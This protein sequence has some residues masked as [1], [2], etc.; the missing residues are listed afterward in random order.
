MRLGNPTPQAVVDAHSILTSGIHGVSS[1]VSGITDS[2]TLQNKIY[3]GD[4]KINNGDLEFG[5][6]CYLGERS[7]VFASPSAGTIGFR[8]QATVLGYT[9][10]HII[11]PGD[12]PLID[13]V[14]QLIMH[15]LD[16]KTDVDNTEMFKMAFDRANDRFNIQ[17]LAYGTG[18]LRDLRFMLQN[19]VIFQLSAT[20][21]RTEF[22]RDIKADLGI[23]TGAYAAAGIR[24][25]MPTSA[26]APGGA[27]E[28]GSTVFDTTNKKIYVYD[29][30]SWLST[31]ALT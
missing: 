27:P 12:E 21:T 26:G 16:F 7:N 15:G 3:D 6:G 17:M 22:K 30:S 25:Q 4:F 5:N 18:G 14:T 11:P 23:L 8:N 28:A 10:L 9:H 24:L 29:G 20:N 13:E 2:E 1:D 31:V 19:N